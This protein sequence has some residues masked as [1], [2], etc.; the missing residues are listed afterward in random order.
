VRR[1]ANMEGLNEIAAAEVT[2]LIED[3]EISHTELRFIFKSGDIDIEGTK[4]A[5]VDRLWNACSGPLR[6]ICECDRDI[7]N[8]PSADLERGPLGEYTDARGRLA[9]VW[10]LVRFHVCGRLGS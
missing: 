10:Y 5:I 8:H 1:L 7:L 4:T 3:G 9:R 6:S 2:H